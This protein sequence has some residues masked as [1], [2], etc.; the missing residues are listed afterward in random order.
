MIITKRY[1]RQRAVQ[2]ATNWALSRN[3]LFYDFSR[4]GGNCT[5]FVS[6]SILAGSCVMNFDDPF[7]WFY[8]SDTERSP[9]W[10]GVEYL[11][12]FLVGAG[13]YPPSGERQG[14]YG[15]EVMPSQTQIGDV[16]QLSRGGDFFV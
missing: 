14:P 13:G 6:Q 15:R 10:T 5:N 11:Y 8:I 3:P 2:Y 12:N 16:V 9:S 4:I 7:G 1:D